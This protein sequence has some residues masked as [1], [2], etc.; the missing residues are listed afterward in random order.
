[1]LESGPSRGGGGGELKKMYS[2]HHDLNNNGHLY[3]NL[4]P[5]LANNNV[6]AE[7]HS[8]DDGTN[9][10]LSPNESKI[11]ESGGVHLS[12]N[13]LNPNADVSNDRPRC[14]TKI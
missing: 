13:E 5:V 14:W 1:M 7:S 3:Q 12:N 8:P 9:R 11:N 6:K 10:V 4:T 2:H